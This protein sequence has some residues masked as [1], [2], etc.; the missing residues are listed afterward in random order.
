MVKKIYILV[1]SFKGSI[2]S[3]EIAEIGKEYLKGFLGEE[4]IKAWSIAD[5]GEG[6][7]QFYIDE[8][9]FTPISVQSVNAF[10][11]PIQTKF[12]YL[13][14]TAIF[15]VAS[16]VGFDVNDHLD[17]KHATTYGIGLVLKEMIARGFKKIYLGLGG[18]ITNDGG[19]GLLEALGAVFYDGDE[20]VV[21]HQKPFSKVTKVDLT[22][23]SKNLS[24][25]TLFGLSDVKN[26]LL[27]SKGATSV[28]GPQKGASI[29]DQA[30][31]ERWMREYQALFDID[32]SI[33]GA[34]AAGGLGFSLLIMHA[35]LLPGVQV[36]LDYLPLDE[37]DENALLITGEGCLDETS[38]DG[39]VVGELY[40]LTKKH[41]NKMAIICGINKLAHDGDLEVFPLHEKITPNYKETVKADLLEAF[42]RI[43]FYFIPETLFYFVERPFLTE[44]QMHLRYNVF[45]IDQGVDEALEFDGLDNEFRQFEIVFNNKEVIA[46]ARAKV[47]KEE[48]TI[49]R[50]V[51]KEDFQGFGIGT[52]LM[53]RIIFLLEKEGV[54]KVTIHAQTRVLGFYERLGFQK[55]GEEFEEAGIKHYQM[56]LEL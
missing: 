22:N 19:S 31:L 26:P 47:D 49:G 7:V 42:E 6:T 40:E 1:D 48:A 41:G 33:S 4:N 15:D 17:I 21:L 53:H 18:S 46:G 30:F 9:G 24:G 32:E 44:Q 14:D 34:G 45:V 50:V 13:G 55:V 25:I 35:T 36:L 37:L 5:G 28:F 38:F 23:L 12:A 29:A 3:K 43:E 56:E 8:L 16:I 51:V 52:F 11:E 10:L 39:K 2:S 20:E 27:G 54:K